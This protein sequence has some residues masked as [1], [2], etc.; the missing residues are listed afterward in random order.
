MTAVNNYFIYNLFTFACYLAKKD[1]LI[2]EAV[3]G[4]YIT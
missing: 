3:K 4:Y 1:R 2:N